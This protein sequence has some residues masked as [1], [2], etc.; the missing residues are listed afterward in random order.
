MAPPSH[1]WG[2]GGGT[3]V[4]NR[5]REAQRCAAARF[6]EECAAQREDLDLDGWRR[7]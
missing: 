7:P 1:L 5:V 6:P 4:R 2:G 3:A